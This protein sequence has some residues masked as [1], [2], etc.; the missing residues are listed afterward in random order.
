MARFDWPGRADPG[1]R[2]RRALRRQGLVDDC[3]LRSSCGVA[4]RCGTATDP[5]WGSTARSRRSTGQARRCSPF[6][7]RRRRADPG[8]AD[9]ARSLSWESR[10]VDPERTCRAVAS[11]LRTVL[12]E[13]QRAHGLKA[14]TLRGPPTM[15]AEKGP[16]RRRSPACIQA[17][18]DPA[19]EQT[20]ATRRR[21]SHGVA[22]AGRGIERV[23]R[24]HRPPCRRA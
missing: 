24:R 20:A 16:A 15:T 21:G 12:K 1:D 14:P 18:R 7:V 9:R 2:E 19:R 13:N 17:L 22:G 11:I 10:S 6:R 5:S 3:L 23:A 8:D 4:S